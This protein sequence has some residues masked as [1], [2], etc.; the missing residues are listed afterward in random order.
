MIV[1]RKWPKVIRNIIWMEH[2]PPSINL[3]S[4]IVFSLQSFPT[5]NIQMLKIKSRPYNIILK[6]TILKNTASIKH[7]LDYFEKEYL[8]CGFFK[9]SIWTA[10]DKIYL[11]FFLVPLEVK[12][13]INYFLTLK[14]YIYG[15]HFPTLA[16]FL[17]LV[18]FYLQSFLP[19]VVF[20]LW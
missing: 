14:N 13:N 6:Q 1:D 5:Y 16:F 12:H 11:F 10:V 20:Y 18:I 9:F 8:T 19:L 3:P 15:I 4:V 17:P 2:F 7:F